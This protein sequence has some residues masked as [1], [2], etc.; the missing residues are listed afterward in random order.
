MIKIMSY[1]AL[2]TKLSKLSENNLYN[3]LERMLIEMVERVQY[4]HLVVY[5]ITLNI[6]T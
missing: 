6:T 5:W 2:E 4:M 1:Y 3:A